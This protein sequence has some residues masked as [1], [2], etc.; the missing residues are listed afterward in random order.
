M[1]KKKRKICNDCKCSFCE[2]GEKVIKNLSLRDIETLQDKI[3][4][5]REREESFCDDDDIVIKIF[6]NGDVVIGGDFKI[7]DEE[8]III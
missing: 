6:A 1:G 3:A 2:G 7:Y 8:K 4:S 5:F